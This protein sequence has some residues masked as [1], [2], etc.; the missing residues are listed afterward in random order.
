MANLKDIRSRIKSVKSTRQITSAMKMVSAA[1]LRKAQNRVEQLRPYAEKL[2]QI[3]SH[4]S[5]SMSG[6]KDFI[7]INE[8]PVK[9][10]LMVII[11]SN[12]GLCGS[13]NSKVVKQ[14]LT[15]MK[16]NYAET[17][18]EVFTI[19]KKANDMMK[20]QPYKIVRSETDIFDDLS[21]DSVSGFADQFMSWFAESTY[22]KIFTV[23][24]SFINTVTQEVKTE[25]Y[26]PMVLESEE[27]DDETYDYIFEPDKDAITKELIPKSLRTQLFKDLLDSAAAEHGARMTAMHQA[28]DNAT[29]L[30]EEITLQYNKARQT[31]ITNELLE[32]TSGA[33]ALKG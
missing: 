20:K 18:V 27:E 33:D 2:Q 5:N 30:L 24:N 3:L 6:D 11:T 28:T 15:F 22:D 23:Y 21:F 4:V 1:K 12:K 8:R 26:L 25:Q 13:F 14:S 32:I 31:A 19:G 9:K 17:E 7:Y 16:E 29:E 10:V